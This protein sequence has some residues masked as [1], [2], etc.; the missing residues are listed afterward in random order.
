MQNYDPVIGDKLG[1]AL[2]KKMLFLAE[3]FSMSDLLEN[4]ADV[5]I[6]NYYSPKPGCIIEYNF[7]RVWLQPDCSVKPGPC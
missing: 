6:L 2:I 7:P 1:S 5:L 4:V 3:I